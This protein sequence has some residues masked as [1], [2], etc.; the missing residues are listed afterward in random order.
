MEVTSLL[1]LNFKLYWDLKDNSPAMPAESYNPTY[2]Q[3]KVNKHGQ[4]SINTF[5]FSSTSTY[6]KLL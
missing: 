4:L 2:H 5:K 6:D 1:R 3:W